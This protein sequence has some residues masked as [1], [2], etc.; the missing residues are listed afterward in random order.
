M[1]LLFIWLA[2]GQCPTGTVG[3]LCTSCPTGCDE[4]SDASTCTTCSKGY[5]LV[6]TTCTACPNNCLEC[7]TPTV[8]IN[9]IPGY[10]TFFNAAGEE[11]CEF[12]W[13]KWFLIFFGALLGI[14]LLG[15]LW[16]M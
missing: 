13:W 16:F 11:E 5:Y 3:F 2:Q 15:M 12:K 10:D 9:C 8:C 1:L 14:F 4:C 6:T 7:E